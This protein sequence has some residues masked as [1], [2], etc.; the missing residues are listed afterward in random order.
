MLARV[1]REELTVGW[2]GQVSGDLSRSGGAQWQGGTS[3]AIY[4]RVARKSGHCGVEFTHPPS[5]ARKLSD[6]ELGSRVV[7]GT[8]AESQQCVAEAK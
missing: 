1:K 2:I 4:K 5:P 8:S 7:G 6:R 3:R